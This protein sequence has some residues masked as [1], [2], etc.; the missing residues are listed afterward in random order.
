MILIP[1]Q[2][3]ILIYTNMITPGTSFMY[4]LSIAI[5]K[6]CFDIEKKFKNNNKKIQI[7]FS[8]SSIPGEG[9]HKIIDH[10]KTHNNTSDNNNT[11]D[12]HNTII[13]ALDGDLIFLA[14]S[15]N[16]SNIY[17][18]RESGS[19]SNITKQSIIH[20]NGNSNGVG[21]DD[22]LFMDISALK[23]CIIKDFQINYGCSSITPSNKQKYIDDWIFLGFMLGN[24]FMPKC[25]WFS[26]DNGGYE[27]LLSAYW[28][29]HNHT[30]DFLVNTYSMTIN[31]EMLCDLLFIVK[32]DEQE[33]I[34]SLFI[35][36]KKTG[37]IWIKEDVS[38]LD[39]QI[40]LMELFP[41]QHLHVETAINPWTD[42]WKD[43]YYKICFHMQSNIDNI[44][45]VCQSYL[46]T[47]VWNFHYY[48]GGLNGCISW[49]WAYLFHYSP[50]WEDVYN[51][52]VLHKNINI[53]GSDSIFKFGSGCVNS[54]NNSLAGGIDSQ[55]LLFMVLPWQSKKYMAVDIVK[56]LNNPLYEHMNIYF[57]KKY[58]IDVAFHRYYYECLP[59]IHK[60]DKNKVIKF[61]KEC[62]FTE[63][64]I[65]R[66]KHQDLLIIN[67]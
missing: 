43:R 4:N 16:I 67:N 19:F 7:I 3:I 54:N 51:E 37:K 23:E 10:I 55:T 57:P 66:N 9:E 5:R 39:R 34:E 59:I 2:G 65:K 49:D 42:G 44:K 36:R 26:I 24:D 27:K 8:D 11:Y 61:I 62:H 53:T 46:K 58:A 31:T 50:C 18:Y 40:K 32:N 60:M 21:T 63:E 15:I 28:Q 38:E 14:C 20:H 12:N 30:E 47:L 22:Y 6:K 25:H 13:Y 45:M 64:E 56:K 48:F 33:S 35:K 1:I 52:L 17:L 29:I 41:L